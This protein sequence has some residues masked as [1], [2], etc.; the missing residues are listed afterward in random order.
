MVIDSID[1]DLRFFYKQPTLLG[2]KEK[3]KVENMVPFVSLPLIKQKIYILPDEGEFEQLFTALVSN[4]ERK[5]CHPVDVQTTKTQFELTLK[6][7]S[8]RQEYCYYTNVFLATQGE[9]LYTKITTVSPNYIICNES[10][11]T[12]WVEQADTSVAGLAP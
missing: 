1:S 5:E 9:Y 4:Y 10:K 3:E 2:D 6:N 11:S 12:I 7:E 8:S